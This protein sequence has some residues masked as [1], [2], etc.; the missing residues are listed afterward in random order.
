MKPAFSRQLKLKFALLITFIVFLLV[1]TTTPPNTY[2][3]C[4]CTDPVSDGCAC[5]LPPPPSATYPATQNTGGI[6]VVCDTPEEAAS[7]FNVANPIC[8][9]NAE[10]VPYCSRHI[11][12]SQ[13]ATCWGT[14][15]DGQLLPASVPQDTNSQ[16]V[17]VNTNVSFNGW[18]GYVTG[19]VTCTS[20]LYCCG[21]QGRCSDPAPSFGACPSSC[22]GPALCT[23]PP[24][25]CS[26]S[27]GG[28]GGT[29]SSEGES[30]IW[31]SNIRMIAAL[32]TMAQSIMNPRN[33]N[34]LYQNT[35][36]S[37]NA[38]QEEL[39]RMAVVIGIPPITETSGMIGNIGS[40]TT[41]IEQ[42]QG[43]NDS[44]R[45]VNTLNN[46]SSVIVGTGPPPYL[47]PF[48]P[49]YQ[50]AACYIPETRENPGDDLLGAKITAEMLFTKA[51]TYPAK[52]RPV[53]CVDDGGSFTVPIGTSIDCAESCCSGS[54]TQQP[55]GSQCLPAF[56]DAPYCPPILPI[57]DCSDPTPPDECQYTEPCD[58]NND[59]DIDYCSPTPGDCS[60]CS[61][62]SAI[63][64]TCNS[65]SPT[66]LSVDAHVEI[67][68]KNPLNEYL[69]ET[70]LRG[71]DSLYRRFMPQL[72]PNFEFEDL[73]SA[74]PF[75][76][77]VAVRN[78][79]TYAGGFNL[80][81]AFG[82]APS[83]EIYF[84]FAGTFDKYWLQNFQT[85]LRPEG[86]SRG[87]P[88]SVPAPGTSPTPAPPG[89]LTCA[90]GTGY[91]SPTHISQI[92]PRFTLEQAQQASGICQQES[93]GN[94]DAEN[95]SCTRCSDG[96]DNDNDGLI[97]LDDPDCDGAS[98]DYSVGLFQIN[99]HPRATFIPRCSGFNNDYSG[100]PDE[101][102]EVIDQ[103]AVDNCAASYK[104]IA[105]E[106]Q[107]NAQ[108]AYDL[109]QCNPSIATCP[110]WCRN[111]TTS[112][113]RCGL[114]P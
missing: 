62:P 67:F 13:E 108:A 113:E 110:G 15:F 69:L 97:D 56:P 40:L 33:F 61:E 83:P 54:C 42:H 100:K 7:Y 38:T 58:I 92:E 109:A 74:S 23:N 79:G 34:N 19:I 51:F 96:I 104:D 71:E 107:R 20:S 45:V 57:D 88:I 43:A 112:A 64:V 24:P 76:A 93:G 31:F 21:G 85:A 11:N 101:W 12:G 65:L 50:N 16:M 103:A 95:F 1:L 91:C 46:N 39:D 17:Q 99:L 30:R 86:Y 84:P 82:F 37:K 29:G 105:N 87:D 70:I 102:C 35:A 26:G 72:G 60:I 18:S 5:Q 3:T 53:G 52:G 81:Y 14:S 36:F 73:P 2:A 28:P 41:R 8:G 106:G 94:I 44:T 9:N 75:G 68:D 66:D 10:T 78:Y 25:F 90:L 77:N 32:S 47:N 55:V 89:P 98:A 59:G 27:S 22:P 49:N 48:Y 111:W 80:D 4:Y 6:S 63:Q 114:C